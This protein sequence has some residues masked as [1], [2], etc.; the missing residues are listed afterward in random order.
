MAM[1]AIAKTAPRAQH[2]SKAEDRVDARLPTETKRV[3]EHAATLI[4]VTVSDFVISQAYRA[5]RTLIPVT[6]IGRLARAQNRV[7]TRSGET[8][9][10]DALRKSLR[11]ATKVGS[12]A[13]V[14]EAIDSR[15]ADFC[16]RHDFIPVKGTTNRLF[17]AMETVRK[18]GLDQA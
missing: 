18:L 4:G 16:Q 10:L 9:L 17:L 5:A 1:L 8:L 15:A 2:R 7:G 14:V 3:I 12:Y 13:V 6:L 11:G